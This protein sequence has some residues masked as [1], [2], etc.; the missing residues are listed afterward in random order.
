MQL[1][2]CKV[3]IHDLDVKKEARVRQQLLMSG[4]R[5]ATSI[6][7]V[8]ELNTADLWI[9]T[10]GSAFLSYARKRMAAGDVTVWL[11][12]QDQLTDLSSDQPRPLWAE[13]IA[14]FV[15]SVIAGKR[16]AASTSLVQRPAPEIIR[17]LRQGM[18]NKQGNLCIAYGAAVFYFDFLL[19]TVKYNAA[20][21][22]VLWSDSAAKVPFAELTIVT[23]RPPLETLSKGCSAFAGIWQM[24]HRLQ[25]TLLTRP[26][27]ENTV[28]KLD[29]W[30]PF[31]QVAHHFD[32]Y[33]MASLLQ[34]RGLNAEQI[35]SLLHLE[36][37]QV[38]AFLNA[39][40]LSA[41]GSIDEHDKVVPANFDAGKASLLA[42]LWRK[43][44]GV[45]SA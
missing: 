28:L 10:Q 45:V 25:E 9:L 34:K 27:T 29:T 32:D 33:R 23:Q 17:H 6:R 3:Y 39:V 20:G 22:D 44:R 8:Q 16:T 2:H 11:H 5:N 24:T 43:V 21:H 35:G 42:G 38:N 4:A 40:Y 30:P 31:E 7:F 18:Q 14:A 12:D 26:L 15:D 37:E 1:R 41:A 13:G 19:L 36:R